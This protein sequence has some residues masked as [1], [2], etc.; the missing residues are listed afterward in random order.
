MKA[1]PLILWL[2]CL[3]VPW[4]P[5][6]ADPWGRLFTTPIQR[7]QLDNGQI[8][9]TDTEDASGEAHQAAR[10]LPIQLTGTLTSSRGKQTVWLN[11]K[12]A[13]KSVRVL[14]AGRVQLRAPSTDTLHFMKSGQL[15]YPQT[16][17][18]VEGYIAAQ[19]EP[20]DNALQAESESADVPM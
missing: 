14:G 8:T 13:P 19:A 7:A 18:I 2:V 9:P 12:P 10:L 3:S 15:L 20:D 5:L 16:G 11:G 17:E 1:L 6:S 4:T